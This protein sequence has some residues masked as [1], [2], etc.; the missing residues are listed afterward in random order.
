[1]K[2]ESRMSVI[3]ERGERYMSGKIG[4]T[5][6][7]LYEC[8]RIQMAPMIRAL[9]RCSA[10]EAMQSICDSCEERPLLQEVGN[11]EGIPYTA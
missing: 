10:D 6:P 1:M 8:P 5:C 2:G 11:A 3:E 9:R 4:L 7:K